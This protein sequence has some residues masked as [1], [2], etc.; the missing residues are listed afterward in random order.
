VLFLGGLLDWAAPLG[1]LGG[2]PRAPRLVAG[3]VLLAGGLALV[4]GGLVA[5][6]RGGTNVE[7]SRPALAL[8]TAGPFAHTRNPLYLGGSLALLGITLAFG[9][10]WTLVLLL[11]S[12]P[13]LH[14]GVVARE[15]RYLERRFGEPYRRYRAQVPRYGWRF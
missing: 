5:M 11:L 14:Y 8:V 3:L 7:P 2:I 12:L 13:L 6:K 10:D 9:L 4:R 1:G 15:E